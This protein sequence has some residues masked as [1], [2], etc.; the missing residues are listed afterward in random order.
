MDVVIIEVYK[1]YNEFG[2]MTVSDIENVYGIYNTDTMNINDKIIEL[3]NLR[4]SYNTSFEIM[5]LIKK[6][7][8]G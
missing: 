6:I 1:V 2:D 3:E 4:T 5:P 7:G 8:K